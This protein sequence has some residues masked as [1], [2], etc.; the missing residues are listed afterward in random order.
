MV[1]LTQL[2]KEDL[3]KRKEYLLKEE[4]SRDEALKDTDSVRTLVDGKRG[5]AFI[6]RGG[7][8]S[9]EWEAIQ[10]MVD[11][12]NLKTMHVKGNEFDA[13]IVYV[14]GYSNVA[15]ELNNIAVKYGGYL[16]VEATAADTR[17][18]GELLGYKKDEIDAYIKKWYPRN[19]NNEALDVDWNPYEETNYKFKI[20]DTVPLEKYNGSVKILN[21]RSSLGDDMETSEL[22]YG[23]IGNHW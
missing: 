9:Q 5:V 4:I 17:R 14:Q 21:R 11:T 12:S 20:G 13:Y 8:S 23:S 3:I 22:D 1:K 6:T 18:I 2:L 19:I 7:N 10:N 16:L 15:T